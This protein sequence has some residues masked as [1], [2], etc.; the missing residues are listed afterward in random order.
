[1]QKEDHSLQKGIYVQTRAIGYPRRYQPKDIERQIEVLLSVWTD[2]NAEYAWNYVKEVLPELPLPEGAEA[3]FCLI[4]PAFFGTHEDA[5]REI[6][7]AL[8]AHRKG[9]PSR[10]VPANTAGTDEVKRMHRQRHT[11]F[12]DYCTRRAN[13]KLD[14]RYVRPRTHTQLAQSEIVRRQPGDLWIVPAQFGRRHIGKAPALVCRSL[15]KQEHIAGSEFG[16]GIAAVGCMMLTNPTRFVETTDLQA[17]CPGDKVSIQ[18][19]VPISRVEN[20]ELSR[21]F[22]DE[23]FEKSFSSSAFFMY[24]REKL[25][26]DAYSAEV[27]DPCAGVVTGFVPLR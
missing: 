7:Q 14:A 26:F 3:A 23:H 8:A 9:P 12:I 11:H 22:K 13:N 1:M 6:L 10:P 25:V 5:N 19:Y 17:Y 21:R 4:N 20:P 18:P 24:H 27:G 2:L 16:L 15:E